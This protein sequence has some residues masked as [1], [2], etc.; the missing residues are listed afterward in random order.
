M[1]EFS[2]ISYLNNFSIK[3]PIAISDAPMEVVFCDLEAS[4]GDAF[5][6][7]FSSDDASVFEIVDAVYWDDVEGDEG[8]SGFLITTRGLQGTAARSWPADSRLYCSITAGFANEVADQLS[9]IDSRVE[10]LESSATVDEYASRLQVHFLFDT[11]RDNTLDRVTEI[12]W[13]NYI[14]HTGWRADAMG[15]IAMPLGVFELV[16]FDYFVLSGARVRRARLVL[17]ESYGQQITNGQTQFLKITVRGA[18][19][20]YSGD[21]TAAMPATIQIV[22]DGMVLGGEQVEWPSQGSTAVYHIEYQFY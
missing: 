14:G 13:E 12:R 8:D 6:L 21:C 10:D 3:I 11:P 2:E 22:Q 9:V 17:S 16:G 20:S 5:T 18:D 1:L 7:T 15:L 4:D 19:S